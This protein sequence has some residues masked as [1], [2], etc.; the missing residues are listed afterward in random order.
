MQPN[1]IYYETARE[2]IKKELLFL[3]IFYIIL[4]ISNNDQKNKNKIDMQQS[5][6]NLSHNFILYT[7][8]IKQKN[9]IKI[10]KTKNINTKIFLRLIIIKSK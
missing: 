2:E 10:E 1:R 5:E 6:S 3:F 4:P 8:N 9:A 7:D